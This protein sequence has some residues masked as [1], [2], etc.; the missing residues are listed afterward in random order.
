M[1]DT[2][3]AALDDCLTA[4]EHGADLEECLRRYPDLAEQLRP[5]LEAVQIAQA[6]I[7]TIQPSPESCMI[8]IQTC[9]SPSSIGR[10]LARTQ[11]GL[12]SCR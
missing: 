5:E 7:A 1:N 12:P 3:I 4:L 11:I 10:P 6:H 2:L 9:P 8:Q